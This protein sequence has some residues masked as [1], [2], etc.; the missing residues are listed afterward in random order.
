M[1]AMADTADSRPQRCR[2]TYVPVGREPNRSRTSRGTIRRVVRLTELPLSSYGDGAPSP[3]ARVGARR[4]EAVPRISS[5]SRPVS[6]P[7]T[8]S[9]DPSSAPLAGIATAS[10]RESRWRP[11]ERKFAE[12]GGEG[13]RLD[14]EV[15]ARRRC[16][17][18][19]IMTCRRPCAARNGTRV[20]KGPGCSSL[21]PR[22]DHERAVV[23]ARV[24]ERPRHAP[25]TQNV[26]AARF[27]CRHSA[28]VVGDGSGCSRRRDERSDHRFTWTHLSARGNTQSARRAR[29]APS[30]RRG[31]AISTTDRAHR[32]CRRSPRSP[33]PDVSLTCR[34]QHRARDLPVE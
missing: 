2:D 17:H 11:P 29:P 23:A 24:V 16:V 27:P 31:A 14:N 25:S 33:T 4:R 13:T 8:V 15:L 30:A 21:G 6:V 28:A 19:R 10:R 5:G 32:P 1:L 9:D 20:G 26:P 3:P 34:R 12:C 18:V 22:T 7:S